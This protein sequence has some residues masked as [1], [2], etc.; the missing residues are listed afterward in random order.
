MLSFYN[1]SGVNRS[2]TSELRPTLSFLPHSWGINKFVFFI[3]LS[4]SLSI[5]LY[6]YLSLSIPLS[7]GRH[8]L[9]GQMGQAH[10]KNLFKRFSL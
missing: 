9:K 4:L 10:P 7:Q 2:Y 5:Y 8:A 1:D 6:F 3:P